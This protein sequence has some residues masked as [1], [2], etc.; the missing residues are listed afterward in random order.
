MNGHKGP[1]NVSTLGAASIISVAPVTPLVF[2]ELR[3][4]G[5]R[6]SD[7]VVLFGVLWVLAIAFATTATPVVR[8]FT[9]GHAVLQN[10]SALAVRMT[11]LTVIA[12]M[13][14][15]IVRDQLPCFIGAPNCD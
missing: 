14:W 11:V 1:S 9:S 5:R 8:R 12:A 10:G 6:V 7:I 3:N 4:N 13:W 2:L 15:G